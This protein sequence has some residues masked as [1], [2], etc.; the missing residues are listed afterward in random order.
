M[1]SGA[2]TGK[3][4]V[5]LI[6]YTEKEPE[7]RLVSSILWHCIKITRGVRREARSPCPDFR[8]QTSVGNVRN[9]GNSEKSRNQ[10]VNQSYLLHQVEIRAEIAEIRG[11]EILARIDGKSQRLLLRYRALRF[12]VRTLGELSLFRFTHIIRI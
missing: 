1:I 10:K 11:L 9:V 4:S 8:F 2:G 3:M 5:P 6:Y 12:N 7:M